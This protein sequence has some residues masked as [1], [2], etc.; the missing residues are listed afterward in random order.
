MKKTLQK[1][2]WISAALIIAALAV[3][4]KQEV[5][6]AVWYK[7]FEEAKTAAAEQEKNILL[8]FT[9]SDWDTVSQSLEAAVFTSGAFL[10]KVAPQYVLTQLDFSQEENSLAEEQ[11][12]KNY[13]VASSFTI[14]GIPTILI[15]TKEGYVV[16]MLEAPTEADSSDDFVKTITSYNKQSDKV[17][18]ALKN[19]EKSEGFKKVKSIDTLADLLDSSYRYLLADL[20]SQIEELDPEN[21]TKLYGKYLLQLTY[22]KAMD[23][24]ANGNETGAIKMLIDIAEGGLLNKADT[25]EA[26][27]SAAYLYAQSPESDNEIV[28]DYLRKSYKVDT[29]SETADSIL[30]T[31]NYIETNVAA[32]KTA[33]EA[34]SGES[35][36]E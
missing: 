29:E 28:L 7:D 23:A 15:V 12:I 22:P 3:S 33:E 27:Y 30:T 5:K 19:I 21:E 35:N 17:I 1:V 24:F 18:A 14:Q 31:I 4:C 34:L 26:Y 13:E 2:L 9:G 36:L 6:E 11:F 10:K 20:F 8:F 32:E 25:Q 16:S